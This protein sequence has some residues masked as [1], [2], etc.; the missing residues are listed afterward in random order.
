MP[1]G[2]PLV[3]ILF[4]HLCVYWLS[5]LVRV[6]IVCLLSHK[7]VAGRVTVFVLLIPHFNNKLVTFHVKLTFKNSDSPFCILW[8]D[9]K[10]IRARDNS[11]LKISYAWKNAKKKIVH[12]M[13]RNLIL[14]KK[15]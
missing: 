11:V 7:N 5:N 10:K 2:K 14:N 1:I 15:L 12:R 6:S 13:G 9:K 4:L 8:W 3:K